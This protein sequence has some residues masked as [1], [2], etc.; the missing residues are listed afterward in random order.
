M[1]Q[2]FKGETM[3]CTVVS[4]NKA[5]TF[6]EWVLFIGFTFVAGWFA[7]GVLVQYFSSKTS[8]SQ[9]EVEV[10]EY[11]VIAIV[12]FDRK[13][14]QVNLTNVDIFY[15]VSGM[16]FEDLV[17]G[18][19]YLHDKHGYNKTQKVILESLEDKRGQRVFRII[20]PTP[21]PKNLIDAGALLSARI[22]VY[23]KHE[24]KNNSNLIVTKFHLTSLGNSPGYYHH[25]WK[26]GKI[27]KISMNEN[28]QV[29]WKI[30]TQITH[31]L[32]KTHN[33]QKEAFYKC[34]A[35]EIDAIE[36]HE[37]S[38][39]CMPNALANIG[40]NYTTPFCQNDT[41]NQHCVF[42]HVHNGLDSKCKRSCSI[43]EYIG[44]VYKN[45]PKSSDKKGQDL[46]SL[47][48][49]LYNIAS[50]KVY[51]EYLIYDGIGMV[52]SVGGTL[53]MFIKV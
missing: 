31:H 38:N 35:S 19:N 24:N 30:E 47:Q 28:T 7:S 3:K 53:G 8:F 50:T 29:N 39:K 18:E 16:A 15:E 51:E 14:S 34:L 25:Y 10:T 40:K 23:I 17:I 26:D 1:V 45:V 46:Y 52:G 20:H 11:P 27:L 21:I 36:F 13:A 4:P 12:F 2:R 33:C 9:H 22:K 37:C 32:E 41:H 43:K 44:A 5:L 6:L 48:Y 42:K 49:Q